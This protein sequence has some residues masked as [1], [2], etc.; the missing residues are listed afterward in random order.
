M[1]NVLIP[2]Y[3]PVEKIKAYG[4]QHLG[5]KEGLRIGKRSGDQYGC[6]KVVHKMNENGQEQATGFQIQPESAVGE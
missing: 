3:W 1:F 2:L 4:K 5:G 6:K